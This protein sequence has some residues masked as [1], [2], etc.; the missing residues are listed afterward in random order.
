MRR[1]DF[2]SLGF[3]ALL[4]CSPRGGDCVRLTQLYANVKGK[5][6]QDII[7]H[8]HLKK[9]ISAEAVYEDASGLAMIVKTSNRSITIRPDRDGFMEVY[10][11]GY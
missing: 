4:G 8:F 3:L 5:A 6:G 1:R 7:L 9:V 11:T 10:V 2:F